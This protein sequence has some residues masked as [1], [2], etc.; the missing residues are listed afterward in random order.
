[1]SAHIP[2]SRAGFCVEC[3]AIFLFAQR[4]PACASQFVM[5]LET[6]IGSVRRPALETCAAA[7]TARA[8]DAIDDILNRP[9][10]EDSNG[11][12]ADHT[13]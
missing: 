2:L 6:W 12:H 7:R 1:M 10:R 5:A 3:E 9:K 13:A 4:C 8:L 11:T